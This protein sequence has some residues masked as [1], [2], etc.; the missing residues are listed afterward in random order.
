MRP[1]SPPPVA[2]GIRSMHEQ[3]THMSQH[4]LHPSQMNHQ[5]RLS[6]PL[7]GTPPEKRHSWYGG[8][9]D[10]GHGGMANLTPSDPEINLSGPPTSVSA[11]DLSL[12]LPPNLGLG[13]N[14]AR[15]NLDNP[16]AIP[17]LSDLST[18]SQPAIPMPSSGDVRAHSPPRSPPI[19]P[20]QPGSSV[21]LYRR[22]AGGDRS[23]SPPSVNQQ[24]QRG[25]L[26]SPSPSSTSTSSPIPSNAHQNSNSDTFGNSA[27]DKASSGSSSAF[28]GYAR[29]AVSSGLQRNEGRERGNS[30]VQSAMQQ[31]PQ[32]VVMVPFSRA[33]PQPSGRRSPNQHMAR[34]GM[35][36][37]RVPT[38]EESH[39]EGQQQQQQ[40]PTASNNDHLG[41]H[42]GQ[43][44]PRHVGNVGSQQN[45]SRQQQRRGVASDAFQQSQQQQQRQAPVITYASVLRAQPQQ[46][47]PAPQ[48]PQTGSTPGVK[49]PG[50]GDPFSLLRELGGGKGGAGNHRGAPGLYHYFA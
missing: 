44:P 18:M 27:G 15:M 41:N 34:G 46:K 48:Q 1:P 30:A 40:R 2:A 50:R 4:F 14:S 31:R 32:Q 5:S 20:R 10:I 17:S 39:S 33:G 26:P 38:S 12:R 47:V 9:T 35:A 45:Q 29:A 3:T 37:I 24:P 36:S 16:P 28:A 13:D 22:R 6:A 42:H 25:F 43:A 23:P 49:G 19:L 7:P 11:F 21:P 8:A